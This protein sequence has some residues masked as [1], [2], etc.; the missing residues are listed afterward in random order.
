MIHVSL[1]NWPLKSWRSNCHPVLKLLQ[2]L[3]PSCSIPVKVLVSLT[4]PIF[5]GLRT[6]IHF[7]EDYFMFPSWHVHVCFPMCPSH[8][9]VVHMH[10]QR[11]R[12][13]WQGP[14]TSQGAP[15]AHSHSC[16]PSHAQ[17]GGCA[18][19]LP[20]NTMVSF[21]W[22][23]ICVWSDSTCAFLKVK[24]ETPSKGCM[25]RTQNIILLLS[26]KHDIP[27]PLLLFL[28]DR[29]GCIF[30]CM[31]TLHKD[32]NSPFCSKDKLCWEVL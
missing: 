5:H 2:N 16:E 24:A 9:C 4:A 14:C 17:P 18:P 12:S 7:K 15:W 8:R 23:R 6:L 3:I 26:P 19:R 29:K 11:A 22:K 20:P 30:P 32:H 27:F 28:F 1:G 10:V 25:Y 13:S 21:A 31:I